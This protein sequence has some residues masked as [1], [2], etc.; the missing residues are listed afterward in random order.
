MALIE[1]GSLGSFPAVND[2][3]A[4]P[5]LVEKFGCE[6][7]SQIRVGGEKREFPCVP[8]V[9]LGNIKIKLYRHPDLL[10]PDTVRAWR[11][12]YRTKMKYGT[13]FETDDFHP[14]YLYADELFENYMEGL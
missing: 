4:H 12:D 5:L 7:V 6:S 9:E 8:T 13:N 11:S 3:S 10:I 14:C 1:S 2:C